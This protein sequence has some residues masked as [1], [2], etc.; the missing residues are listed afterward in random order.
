[1]NEAG[2][3]LIKRFEGFRASRYLCPAGKPT[4]GYGHVILP[5]EHFDAQITEGYADML[6]RNDVRIIENLVLTMIG[7]ANYRQLSA[8]VCFAYNVGTANLFNSTLLRLFNAGD[9][10]GA[11]HQFLRWTKVTDP[12]TGEKKEL[13]GL[14]ARRQAEKELFEKETWT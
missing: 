10:A 11:A 6:L 1:M 14:V 3:N 13:P 8:L 12:S 9:A 2:F 5:G 7:G 4:I